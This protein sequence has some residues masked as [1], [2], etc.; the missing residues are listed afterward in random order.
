MMMWSDGQTAICT[1]AWVILRLRESQSGYTN[2]R[3]KTVF[4]FT[5]RTAL[6]FLLFRIKSV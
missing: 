2:S 4:S 6:H 3:V 5:A 1:L